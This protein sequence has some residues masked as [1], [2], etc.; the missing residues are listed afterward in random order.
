LP[1]GWNELLIASFA[2]RSVPLN[3]TIAL[4]P[5]VNMGRGPA[6]EQ[7]S[8]APIFDR[9]LTDLVSKMRAMFVDRVELGCLRVIVLFNP[10]KS[11]SVDQ[12]AVD[13]D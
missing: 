11:M 4:S 3:D 8:I 13:S 6:S 12:H 2:H 10:G 9:I 1:L 7:L 5:Y